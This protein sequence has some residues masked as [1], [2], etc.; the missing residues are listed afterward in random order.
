MTCLISDY[1]TGWLIVKT[2]VISVISQVFSLWK[3]HLGQ[4][5]ALILRKMTEFKCIFFSLVFFIYATYSGIQIVFIS[6]RRSKNCHVYAL[7]AVLCK[8]AKKQ[9]IN[10]LK[11]SQ[12]EFKLIV[13]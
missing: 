9:K 11:F 6:D 5:K 7:N 1:E 12:F 8:L 10:E 2:V 13:F 3:K 4:S